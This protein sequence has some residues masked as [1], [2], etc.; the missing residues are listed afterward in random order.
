MA[1]LILYRTTLRQTVEFNGGSKQISFPHGP[2]LFFLHWNRSSSCWS[3]KKTF[4]QKHLHL[5]T[6]GL[7]KFSLKSNKKHC[8]KTLVQFRAILDRFGTGRVMHYINLVRLHFFKQKPQNYFIS[9]E[10]KDKSFG[11]IGR[12]YK[13]STRLPSDSFTTWIIWAL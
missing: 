9:E 8:L 7:K 13:C 12:F 4:S 2:F 11:L 6:F 1:F 5:L 3:Q 10:K